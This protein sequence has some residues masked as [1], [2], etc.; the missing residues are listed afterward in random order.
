ME[1]HFFRD[2]LFHIPLIKERFVGS[3]GEWMSWFPAY[4]MIAGIPLIDITQ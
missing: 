2:Y 1:N 3:N 4:R